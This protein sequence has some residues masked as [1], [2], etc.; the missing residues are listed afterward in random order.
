M[1]KNINTFLKYIS[2]HELDYW[3]V[4]RYTNNNILKF[5]NAIYLKNI[6]VHKRESISKDLIKKNK[7]NII[8]KINF[9]GELFLRNFD[10]IE[11]YKGA[12]YK[13]PK[14]SIIYSKI[15]VRHGCIYYNA[16]DK[17]PFAV[18]SEYPIFT[19]DNKKV[20][21]EYLKLVLRS[22]SFKKILDT[23]ISGISK[24]R[25]K[26]DEFLNIKIPLPILEKQNKLLE[27]YNAKLA[28]AQNQ[29][30]EVKEI[31]DSIEDFF[32][33]EIGLVKNG[34]KS[35]SKILLKTI[36]Y[37]DTDKWGVDKFNL[38]N[39]ITY[40]KKNPQKTIQS[41]ATVS[42]GG[43][44]S[45]SNKEYYTGK[46]PWIKTGE[47]INDV[48]ID[49]DE[50]IT[51]EAIKNSSAKI[52]PKDSLIIAMYGQGLTRGRTAKLGVDASTNQACAVLSNIDNKLIDTDYLWFYLMNEYHRLRELA[53]GNSQP[54]LNAE[55]I[56]SYK[57]VIPPFDIQEKIVNEI[58]N[59]KEK[60]K[61][62]KKEAIMNRE[63]AIK[64]FEEEIF[65]V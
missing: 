61:Q 24:A 23:K 21:G 46:I 7:W 53:S 36:N 65:T 9:S 55:M 31:E 50:K 58:I 20:N 37:T 8:S 56:K 44:P 16:D 64:E 32:N 48:I 17:T 19:F 2:L 54:N 5:D 62:L 22:N 27:R 41:I 45:R 63:S 35:K 40:I 28:L 34:N 60:I 18:S 3:D 51:E 14:N 13:V 39:N 47:V 11:T 1:S 30:K 6:L 49:T 4:K 59:R 33:S 42:S 57:V 12:L 52:Y 25:V 38:N 26:V 29:E 10:E 15:N 43:T